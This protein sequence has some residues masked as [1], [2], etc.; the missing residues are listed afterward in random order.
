MKVKITEKVEAK[1]ETKRGNGITQV[2]VE[3]E[4]ERV[5]ALPNE[6]IL[7]MEVDVLSEQTEGV[8]H[9]F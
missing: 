1:I 4:I 2:E 6:E 3:M 8:E 7:A 5:A 9:D